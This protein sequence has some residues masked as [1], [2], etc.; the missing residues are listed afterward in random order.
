MTRVVLL[1]TGLARAG[2]ESQVA[3]CAVALRRRGWETAVVSLLDPTAFA[4]E[5]AAA[6]VPV[7]SL[8]MRPGRPDP[9]GLLRLMG[10]LR[11]FRPRILHSHMFHANLAARLV[12][13]YCPVPVVISTLHS[14]A[15]SSRD[16]NRVRL[17]DWA[18]RL[19]DPLAD[20]VTAVS[21]AVAERHRA[22]GA[23][24]P[25]RLRV[26]P[27][28][29]DTS[30]Y[31]PDPARRENARREL[32]IAARFIWLAAG[33]LMWKK[34]YATLLRAFARQADA[35][36]LIAGEGPE[37]DQLRHQ[38][39]ELAIDA[40]FLG[41]RE[42]LPALMNAADGFVL[43]SVVEG[44][45]M[46]LIEAAASGLPAVAADAGGVRECV[47]DGET[48]FVVPSADAGALAAAMSRLAA[49]P[50]E[51][52]ARLSHA[53]RARAVERFDLET[54]V[55]EWER[56]YGEMLARAAGTEGMRQW[57]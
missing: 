25:A 24:R 57:T 14:V 50:A 53:A 43:S 41:A 19:T 21:L 23:V 28:G 45:P 40:R 5:L 4:G 51:T 42:D 48:G 33:R 11:V 37:G 39:R 8:R 17:R 44:L 20:L 32:G 54:V 6:A 38:A 1:T 47:A 52:R 26:I 3:Q 12:R 18:Y 34:D 55:A 15:E 16:T 7:H 10:F 31:R 27:N 30:R 36:L 13:L 56:T 49:A 29:V 35:V 46:V 22:S 9:R 2:A